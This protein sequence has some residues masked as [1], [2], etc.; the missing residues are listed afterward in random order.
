MLGADAEPRR[1]LD[2]QWYTEHL[3]SLGVIEVARHDYLGLLRQALSVDLPVAFTGA[4]EA[5]PDG[6]RDD[7]PERA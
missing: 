3:G 7:R 2:V 5:M 6:G 4:T 1:L